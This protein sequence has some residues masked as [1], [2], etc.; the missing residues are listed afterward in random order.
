MAIPA[1][2]S[3]P[4]G[5]IDVTTVLHLHVSRVN[6]LSHEKH[7]HLSGSCVKNITSLNGY[8]FLILNIEWCRQNPNVRKHE[9]NEVLGSMQ[10]QQQQDEPVVTQPP[11]DLFTEHTPAETSLH[12]N[13]TQTP[14]NISR[15]QGV[16]EEQNPGQ[17]VLSPSSTDP[18]SHPPPPYT[19]AVRD[20][21]TTATCEQAMCDEVIQ[22]I[23]G[24]FQYDYDI[25]RNLPLGEEF[26]EEAS[27]DTGSPNRNKGTWRKFNFLATPS[28]FES[29]LSLS[30]PSQRT[31][32]EAR[33][34]ID[35]INL[36]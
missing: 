8:C 11:F 26:S 19:T 22:G 31:P 7:L 30:T 36:K 10:Q 4:K 14:P 29:I 34:T 20:M 33:I 16:Q 15:T 25:T 5:T 27:S 18:L 24:K 3:I 2:I 6:H 23:I 12:A 35:V 17:W 32:Y 1:I 28:A 9:A 21:Q 13:C